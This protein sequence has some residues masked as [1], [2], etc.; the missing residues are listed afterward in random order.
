MEMGA[1]SLP[2]AHLHFIIKYF[3]PHH[4]ALVIIRDDVQQ[5]GEERSISKVS[6][7]RVCQPLGAEP[8]GPIPDPWGAGSGG[9]AFGTENRR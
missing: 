5:P 9:A 8:A 4:I 2:L 3:L 6:H 1:S 7:S